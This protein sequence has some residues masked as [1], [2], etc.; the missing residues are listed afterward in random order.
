MM[1]E[2]SVSSNNNKNNNNTTSSNDNND[3]NDDN[4]SENIK[5]IIIK[6][7]KTLPKFWIDKYKSETC[8]NWDLF[9]RRNTTKFFKNRN[10]IG[11]EFVELNESSSQKVY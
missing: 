7:S 11:R 9:Y 6:D 8:K 1:S 10:W 2:F 4:V 3:D 5:E